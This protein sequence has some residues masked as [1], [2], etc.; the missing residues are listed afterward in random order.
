M[1]N[2][3]RAQQA[4]ASYEEREREKVKEKREAE[5]CA[6]RLD[7][8]GVLLENDKA[9]QD[10]AERDICEAITIRNQKKKRG[11]RTFFGRELGTLAGAEQHGRRVRLEARDRLGPPSLAYRVDGLADADG[12]RHILELVVE[13]DEHAGAHGRHKRIQQV[14]VRAVNR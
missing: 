14:R 7:R 8:V 13:R 2:E 11:L 10:P 5:Q 12:D 4:A 6:V 9:F 1:T 3:A